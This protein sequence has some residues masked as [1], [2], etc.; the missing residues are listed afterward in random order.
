MAADDH[1]QGEQLKMFTLPRE[2]IQQYPLGDQA[3]ESTRQ[4]ME[5]KAQEADKPN[6]QGDYEGDYGPE[7]KRLSLAQSINMHGVQRPVYVSHYF[8][9]AQQ[10]A[11]SMF[12]NGH[13][14]LAVAARDMPDTYIP[15]QHG[16]SPEFGYGFGTPE[17]EKSSG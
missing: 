6:Y 1:L 12:Q 7:G 9:Q 5:R 16:G 3:S 14:R 17:W 15:V 13:H 2:I 11:Y 4:L 10:S 8:S